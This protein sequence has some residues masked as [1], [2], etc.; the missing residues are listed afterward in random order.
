MNS[1]T[2]EIKADKE[3]LVTMKIARKEFENEKK[4]LTEMKEKYIQ[5]IECS[6]EELQQLISDLPQLK[7][8][9]KVQTYIQ[10]NMYK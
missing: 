8:G 10:M 1:L 5:E 4:L 2:A 9:N 7:I 3:K 6:N